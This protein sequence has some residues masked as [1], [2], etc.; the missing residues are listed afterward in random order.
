MFTPFPTTLVPP[1][2]SPPPFSA[3]GKRSSRIVSRTRV[4]SKNFSLLSLSWWRRI[5]RKIIY[6]AF[7]LKF[8]ALDKLRL[9]RNLYG[10]F[11]KGIPGAILWNS[12]WNNSV[13]IYGILD[14]KEI[15]SWIQKLVL[16][17]DNMTLISCVK[18]IRYEYVNLII[19]DWID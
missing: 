18:K 13:I 1:P 9:K 7:L 2:P 17:K 10:F 19:I 6:F 5:A 8:G 3:F 11:Y 12:L 4:S 14:K 16:I 15:L